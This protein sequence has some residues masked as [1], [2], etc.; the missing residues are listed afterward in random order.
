MHA[1]ALRTVTAI[2]VTPFHA[3]GSVDFGAYRRVV[4]RMV[5]GG[6]T[7]MTPNG[8]TGE[9]Y[10]LSPGEHRSVLEAAVTAAADRAM[11]ISGIGFDLETA[12]EMGRFAEQAG[13]QGVMV[14]QPIHPYQSSQGW[15][16]YHAAIADAL[17]RL[18]I[19]P[20]VRDPAVTAIEL[21]QL[22]ESPNV[23]GIKYA[24]G[25]LDKF[26]SLV[27][28]IGQ[29]RLAWVCGLAELWAPFFWLAGAQGFTS[30][31]ANVTAD[32]PL[33]MLEHLRAGSYDDAMKVWRRVRPFEALRARHRNANN[34]SVIKEALAQVG[35]C[36]RTVRPPLTELRA[37][38]REELATLL[39]SL[40]VVEG[41]SVGTT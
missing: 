2:P 22:L 29:D 31:L 25:D 16:A 11:V 38:E 41:A 8:N 20:Y 32:L 21:T 33:R 40:R 18:G 34:V 24:V 13:A 26:A 9:F 10:A 19:V 27:D 1:D 39:A 7:A 15:V 12:I 23:V 5:A 6:I 28:A 14:H 4:A 36:R 17:P 30:G 3:D 35:L 37:G